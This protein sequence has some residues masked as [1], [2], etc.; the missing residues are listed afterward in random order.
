MH[1]NEMALTLGTAL[2]SSSVYIRDTLTPSTT[3]SFLCYVYQSRKYNLIFL[4]NYYIIE[5]LGLGINLP[6]YDNQSISGDLY[7]LGPDP[8]NRPNIRGSP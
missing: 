6:G 5:M 8:Q 4:F 2:G 3:T 7:S 1:I